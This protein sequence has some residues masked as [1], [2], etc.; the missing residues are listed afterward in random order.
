[1]V[2]VGGSRDWRQEGQPMAFFLVSLS[3]VV[4]CSGCW[5]GKWLGWYKGKRKMKMN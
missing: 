4:N 2:G 3:T 1:M 5:Q